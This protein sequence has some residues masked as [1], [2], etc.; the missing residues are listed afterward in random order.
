MKKVIQPIDRSEVLSVVS[1]IRKQ[2]S[3]PSLV[4]L[5]MIDG[6]FVKE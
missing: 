5:E 2:G 6:G 4:H 1:F 3:S